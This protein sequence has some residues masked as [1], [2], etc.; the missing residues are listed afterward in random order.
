MHLINCS[1]VEFVPTGQVDEKIGLVV[2]VKYRYEPALDEPHVYKFM[3]FT[4]TGFTKQHAI[5]KLQQA[6]E[7]VS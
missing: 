3:G 6:I 5:E 7:R 1:K 2:T 4:R